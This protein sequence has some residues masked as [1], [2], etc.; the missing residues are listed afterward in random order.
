MT[1]H[2][3]HT[4]ITCQVLVT[5]R[6][7]TAE[8]LP[9]LEW[10]GQY[11]HFRSLFRRTFR[12]QQ[13]GRRLM[14]LADVR[15]FPIGHIFIHLHA[16]SRTR[17]AECAYFYSFRVMEMFRGQGIGTRLLCE[18]ENLVI[19]HGIEWATIAAAKANT[20]AQRLYQ[21]LGYRIC[22]DDDGIWSYIDHR[23][24]ICTVNEPCWLLEKQLTSG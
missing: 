21:R 16:E 1:I 8:D 14:L 15:G 10:Y 4:T 2:E 13:A 6:L 20:G 5:L 22:G 24:R 17:S 7:A 3:R 19:D 9:K 18:A 11:R 12:E 23:G